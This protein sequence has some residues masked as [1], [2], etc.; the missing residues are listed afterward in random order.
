VTRAKH[1][2]RRFGSP[3]CAGAIDGSLIPQRKPTKEQANQDTDSYFGYKG[4]IAS[5]LLAICDAEGKF[6]YVSAG[7]PA[8]VGDA[9]LFGR[10]ILKERI[11]EGMLRCVQIPLAMPDGPLH[12]IYPYLVGDAAFP[13]GPHMLKVYEPPPAIGTP[14]SELNFRLTNA[15]RVIEMTFGRLKGRW[16]FCSKNSFWNDVKFTRDSI[17]ACCGL[18]NFLEQRLVELP[19][20]EEGNDGQAVHIPMDAGVA[21]EPLQQN[22][23]AVAGRNLRDRVAAWVSL[24]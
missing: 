18:H 7:A 13:I 2:L 17:E 14:Q 23:Q 15:R 11:D 12:Q 4:A 19:D 22:G 9:G 5:L 20:M 6:L 8:C 16:V 1:H 21:D 10:S 3:G 24:N